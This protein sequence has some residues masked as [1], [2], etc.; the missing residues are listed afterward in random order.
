VFTALKDYAPDPVTGL[1]PM[2]I[3]TV[4]DISPAGRITFDIEIEQWDSGPDDWRRG[5]IYERP[6]E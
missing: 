5:D 2:S 4:K 1:D 6:M 3:L